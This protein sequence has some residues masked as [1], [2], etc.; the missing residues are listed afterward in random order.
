MTEL[1]DLEDVVAAS[2]L[3]EA[4]DTAS[5]LARLGIPYALVG[6]LAVGLR[7]FPRATKDVDFMVGP[8]A[9]ETTEPL[10]I[11]RDELKDK[12]EIGAVDLLAVPTAYP[13]L[14]EQLAVTQPGQLHVIAAEPLI[15]MKLEANRPQDRADVSR[16]LQAG[17]DAED[18][19]AYLAE[20][21]P[22][23]L[24]RFAELLEA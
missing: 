2:V 18:V 20:H 13:V 7:G 22:T 5:L 3:D 21:A 8:E 17:V 10:L 15:L 4:A 23:L 14:A 12:V 19:A 1:R 6:G 24:T 16:L 9:F 11:Y